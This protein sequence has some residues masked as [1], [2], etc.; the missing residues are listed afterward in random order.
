[1][2]GYTAPTRDM[3]FVINELGLLPAIQK[4][5]GCEDTNEELVDAVLE[6]AGKLAG[7]VLAPI[8]ASGDAQ[9]AVLENGVVRT[10]EGFSDAYRQ[11]VDGGWNSVPFDPDYGGQGLPWLVGIATEEMWIAANNAWSLCPMLTMGA[12]DALTHHGTDAQKDT[13]LEKLIS[14]E[15]TGTMNLTEPHAG[16]DVGALRTRAV[17]EG[18]HYRIKGQKIFIT[19][20]EHDMA[21]NIVHLVLART[22]DAPPGS[23]GI[24]LFIVPKFLVNEDGSLGQRNDLR[25]VSLEHKLGIKASPTCVMSY[26]DDEGAIGYLVGEENKGLACMFTM[27]NNAR[28][29][30]GLSGLAIAERAYQ[31]AVDYAR[32]RTQGAGPDG[33]PM[34]I[35]HYPDVRRMLL[36][37]KS[38]IEAM[39]ALVY[40][41]VTSLD[42]SRRAEDA[43]ARQVAQARVDLLTPVVKAWCTDLGVEIASTAIQVHGGV[44]YMEETGAVQHL[45]DSR[46][47]PIYEGTNGIQAQDL[48]ARKVLRDGGAAARTYIEE[49]RALC[50]TLGAADGDT[51]AALAP[52][53][54]A[55]CDALAETTDW[56]LA[57]GKA[58]MAR[59]L[60]GATPYLRLFAT[61]AGGAMM[62]RATL[63][64]QASLDTGAGDPDFYTAKLASARFYAENILPQAVGLVAPVRDGHRAVLEFNEAA[65]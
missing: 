12:I 8:N 30:V 28:I 2:T 48:V 25:C 23:K 33:K 21:D 4:L 59:V 61:V 54:A 5:P 37:M 32:E 11:F 9:G 43:D 57:E 46:I 15:W 34:A 3:R 31:Q 26:G 40:D 47:A 36:T 45:R 60:A 22:P 64:A 58:D 14:G 20:G 19:W 52:Q 24:S 53:L 7:G 16:S 41:T 42:Q 13:Y 38:Q 44:G 35:I 18:D 39:R 1:M 17:P 6:E 55:G 63:A 27:M 10:A 62:A 56:L 51:A 65:F 49:V 50:D 29:N